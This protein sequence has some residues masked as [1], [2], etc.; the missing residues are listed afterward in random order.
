MYQI[1]SRSFRVFSDLVKNFHVYSN[2][3]TKFLCILRFSPKISMYIKFESQCVHIQSN[4][5]TKFPYVFRFSHKVS[6][7]IQIYQKSSTY[8]KI[9]SQYFHAYSDLVKRIQR[10][11]RFIHSVSVYIRIQSRI[12][13]QIFRLLFTKFPIGFQI[14]HEVSKHI[15]TQLQC[16]D[17]YSVVVTRFPQ[18][19]RLFRPVRLLI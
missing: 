8:I 11:L 12:F 19:L 9:Q 1:Q 15:Q 7:Y 13:P 3:V 18:T 2:L 17:G 5:L 10:I 4:L 6:V 16:S 14:I